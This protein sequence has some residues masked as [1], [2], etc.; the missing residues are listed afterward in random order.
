[1]SHSTVRAGEGARTVIAKHRSPK[2]FG[3]NFDINHVSILML[4]LHLH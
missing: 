1:M 3:E 2:D 4:A